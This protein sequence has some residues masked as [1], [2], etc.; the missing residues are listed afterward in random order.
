MKADVAKFCRT[1]ETCQVTGKPNQVIPRAP[2]VPIPVIGEPFE[3]VVI[4]C[5]GPL[6]KSR[7]GNQFLLTVMCTATRFPEAIPLRRITAPVISKA[8]VKFFSVFGLPRIVQSDQGTNF[9]SKLFSQVLKTLHI[10][11]RTSSA[12]HPESQGALERFHRRYCLDTGRDWDEGVPL[13]LFAIREVVQESLGFSPAD[14]VFGHSVRGPLKMLREDMLSSES[15]AKTNILDYVSKFCECLHHAC[16]FAKES[17]LKAQMAMKKHFDKKTVSRHF[18]KGD[19]VLVLM[20]VMGSVLSARFSGPYEVVK[21][22][23]E[24]D[25][26]IHTPDRRK[27]SCVCHINMIKEYHVRESS[28]DDSVKA[29]GVV[30]DTSAVALACEVTDVTGALDSEDGMIVRH[31]F[32]QCARLKKMCRGVTL[33]R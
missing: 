3:H 25:Y 18:K 16:S 14:L 24:T 12:F 2:L 26:L 7:A 13:L 21:K 32:Q 27:K 15:S 17:L 30:A 11:H 20:P 29:E 1:C 22:L 5:V 23:S 28:S 31:T 4:D 10:T 6:P 8:L 33:S 19:R 9:L